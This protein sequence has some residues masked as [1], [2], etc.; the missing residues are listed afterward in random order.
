MQQVN[1]Q[2]IPIYYIPKTEF[3]E[4]ISRERADDK[5]FYGVIK[6]ILDIV[7]SI[8]ALVA[9]SPLFAVFAVLIRLEDGGP[10]IHTRICQGKNGRLYKMYKFRS[11]KMN[12][13]EMLASLSEKQ[14]SFYDIGGK[15]KDDPR[16]TEIGKFIRK[17]SIDE[18]P[19]LVS[20]VKGDMSIIGPRPVTSREADAYGS[21]KE[22]LLSRR[23]GLTGYW[24][25]YGR[26]DVCFLSEEAKAMQLYYVEHFGWKLDMELFFKTIV[27][28]LKMQG[29]R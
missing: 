7:L 11:M 26:G 1:E 14:R 8:T 24:Q 20:I 4:L 21:K 27:K 16:I 23:A 12:A 28:V 15:L 29:A 6:R 5:L 2:T 3:R 10:A 22:L 13:D 25:V 19:Q 18:L 9:L 17:T